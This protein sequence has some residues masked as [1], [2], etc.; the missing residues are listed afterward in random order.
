MDRY[1]QMQ[2]FCDALV[3]AV[4]DGGYRISY[5]AASI[6]ATKVLRKRHHTR[7]N[8]PFLDKEV[9]PRITV[10]RRKDGLVLELDKSHDKVF[11]CKRELISRLP[12]SGCG[13]YLTPC[14]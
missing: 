2:L 7:I 12:K 13:V 5:Y 3:E 14:Q 1:T 11:T 9:I 10:N 4:V 6:K 8:K